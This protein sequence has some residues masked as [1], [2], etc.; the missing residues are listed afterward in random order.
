[1]SKIK[2]GIIGLSK[3]NG[4]PY[5]WSAIFNG[6]DE[7]FMKDCPFPSIPDYLSKQDYP[8]D[9]LNL[10]GNVNAIWTQDIEISKHVSKASKIPI[11]CEKITDLINYSDAIL[12]AR[13]DA[14][15][16]FEMSQF[17]IDKGIPIFIDK[18]FSLIYEEA[19]QM[20]LNQ[21]LDSQIFTC[22][23]LRYADELTLTT[24]DRKELN[25]IS[26]VEA[27]CPKYW[28]TYAVHILEPIIANCPERGQLKRINVI[29]KNPWH[30]V[31][32]EWENM[33]GIIHM[34]LEDPHSI[35]IIYK[36]KTVQIKKT[37]QDSFACFKKSLLTF[38]EQV[39]TKKVQIPRSETLEIVKILENGK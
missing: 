37:F 25:V 29:S 10:I 18:P 5:S 13:D 24:S 15:N 9:F 32:I 26:E 16:H 11:V 7:N 2:L 12:L 27:Y 23:S 3:G 20:I 36:S 34:T 1:M 38:A 21:R 28:N 8:S 19:K 31:M 17:F 6:Y 30:S 33:K 35:D 14:E 4:H 22:S 39:K